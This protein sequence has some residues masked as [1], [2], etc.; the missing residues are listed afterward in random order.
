[1]FCP[2]TNISNARTLNPTSKTHLDLFDAKLGVFVTATQYSWQRV[3]NSTKLRQDSSPSKKLF[4]QQIEELLTTIYSPIGSSNIFV[5]MCFVLS[6]YSS[7][8]YA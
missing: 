6:Y 7:A 3:L 2:D 5:I 4:A 8:K 1:M